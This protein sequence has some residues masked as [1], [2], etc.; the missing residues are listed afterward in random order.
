MT[1]KRESQLKS[2]ANSLPKLHLISVANS[3][4][5]SLK[6]EAAKIL[7][8]KYL[9]TE[10]YSNLPAIYEEDRF[11]EEI[12]I[13]AGKAYIAY[14]T[15]ENYLEKLL[16]I[17]DNEKLPQKIRLKAENKTSE[18]ADRLIVKYAEKGDYS[19]LINMYNTPLLSSQVR[20]NAKEVA[21]K[22]LEKVIEEYSK[23]EKKEK[24]IS[25]SKNKELPLSLRIRA[26]EKFIEYDTKMGMFDWLISYTKEKDL[27]EEVQEMIQKNICKAK[28][29]A[30]P[31]FVKHGCYDYLIGLSK[32]EIL[33][34][35]VRAKALA[36]VPKSAENAIEDQIRINGYNDLINISNDE[37]LPLRVRIKAR[38]GIDKVVD[39]IIKK[40]DRITQSF[41]SCKLIKLCEDSR[42]PTPV[43]IRCAE[44]Y[45]KNTVDKEG[46]PSYFYLCDLISDKVPL[47]AKTKAQ[48]EIDKLAYRLA[49]DMKLL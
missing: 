38:D 36:S 47:E 18:V 28:K 30:I 9:K 27:P 40:K 39:N 11:S 4:P 8:N 10:R 46:N 24:L 43:R 15:K 48:E 5:D 2:V 37:N 17:V 13:K 21:C 44:E 34:E 35:R 6:A 1:I 42:L 14:A 3:L 32:D 12:R 22:V 19:C 31:I 45:I 26:G 49:K 29:R 25:L 20:T 7:L 16:C 41:N 23:L 33:S